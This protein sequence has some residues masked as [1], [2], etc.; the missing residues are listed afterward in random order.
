MIWS[1]VRAAMVVGSAQD[2]VIVGI[3]K[4]SDAK[5]RRKEKITSWVAALIVIT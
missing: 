3:A 5:Q 2:I 1:A 4:T